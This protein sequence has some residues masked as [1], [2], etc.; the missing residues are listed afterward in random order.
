[1]NLFYL[2]LEFEDSGSEASAMISGATLALTCML[3]TSRY[4]REICWDILWTSLECRH[5]TGIVELILR[6]KLKQ[7]LDF[8]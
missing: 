6:N 1:M 4:N 2:Q 7:F 5:R 8:F 3:T